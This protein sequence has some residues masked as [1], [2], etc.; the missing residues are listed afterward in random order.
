MKLSELISP[1]FL[2][3]LQRR[4]IKTFRNKLFELKF[5]LMRAGENPEKLVNFSEIVSIK[6]KKKKSIETEPGFAM[7]IR[8]QEFSVIWGM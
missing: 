2:F 8:D 4:K 7:I 5:A 6:K 3:C 1:R